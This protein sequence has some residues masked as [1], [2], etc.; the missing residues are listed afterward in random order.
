MDSAPT[1]GF[2]RVRHGLLQQWK[3]LFEDQEFKDVEIKVGDDTIMADS[4][5]LR[6]SSPV[7]AAMLKHNMKEAQTMKLEIDDSSLGE[8]RFFVRLLYTGQ[9]DPADWKSQIG[10]EPS[11]DE[12][13]VQAPP[14]Q[15]A[16]VLQQMSPSGQ[17]FQ[18]SPLP[19]Q[20]APW[21]HMSPSGLP[22]SLPQ[23]QQPLPP[24][25][26]T[27][28]DPPEQPAESLPVMS[29]SGYVRQAAFVAQ[30]HHAVDMLPGFN[31]IRSS[32]QTRPASGGPSACS[33]GA[34]LSTQ[35][36]SLPSCPGCCCRHSC[37]SPPSLW[38]PPA[39][40]ISPPTSTNQPPLSLLLGATRLAKKYQVEWLL[41]VLIDVVNSRIH[42]STFEQIVTE[43][44][45]NDLA[46]VRL[47]A[48]HFAKS[49]GVIREK[50]ENADYAPEVLYELQAVFPLRQ[51]L[52]R[53]MD[54]PL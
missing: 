13:G 26:P 20:P 33:L 38:S 5:V 11:M 16:P 23:S 37:R 12:Q 40:R 53:E 29:P 34:T 27:L 49:S 24:L 1:L 3:K 43:A 35:Q 48:L 18:A 45:E 32:E 50:Y 7:F 39:M 4:L 19:Q 6:M 51:P 28:P 36:P 54:I 22:R 41:H 25:P 15:P 14:R 44:V 52:P 46:P 8:F 10:I 47:C 9:M 21:Q 31:A 2:S 42:E 30:P 17:V